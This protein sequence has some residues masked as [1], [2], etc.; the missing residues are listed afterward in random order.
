M[1]GGI[2]A[3][4]ERLYQG[5]LEDFTATRNALAKQAG[6]RGGEIRALDKP[7]VAAWAVN[8]LYWHR[9]PVY[10]ALVEAAQDLR[11]AHAA[12]L[13]GRTGDVRGAGKAH[14]ERVGPALDAALQLLSESGHPVTDATRQAIATTLRA[15]PGDEPPGRLTRTLQPGGFEALA[16]LSIRGAKAPAIPKPTATPRAAPERGKRANES[17]RDTKALARARDAL[18]AASRALKLAEHGAQREEFER[19]RAARDADKA[20]KSTAAARTA[21]EEA[22]EAL[23]SAEATATAATRKKEAAERR[24]Q[25]AQETVE[26]ARATVAEAQSDLDALSK[27]K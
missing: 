4:I 23:R 25:Q 2:D 6:K 3:E 22:E 12:V 19:V 24:A 26:G 1:K 20:V 17:A 27:G 16:G 21:L 5:P 10:D 14:D 7:S 8:Q 18:A 11:R 15:L 13:A 9:R